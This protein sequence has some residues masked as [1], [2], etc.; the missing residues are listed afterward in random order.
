M[1]RLVILSLVYAALAHSCSRNTNG[2]D[3]PADGGSR[4]TPKAKENGPIAMDRWE[5]TI[6]ESVL[7]ECI[8]G[9]GLVALVKVDSVEI[10]A[11]GTRGESTYI[12]ATIQQFLLG[13]SADE[14]EFW[15]NTSG[16]NKVLK[17]G[18]SYIVALSGRGEGHQIPNVLMGFVPVVPATSSAAVERHRAAIARLRDAP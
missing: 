13:K 3:R 18:Q 1:T 16:G 10:T 15:R 12:K 8:A 4:A 6:P 11:A 7:K 9:N 2:Q 5:Q 17:Q 14:Q